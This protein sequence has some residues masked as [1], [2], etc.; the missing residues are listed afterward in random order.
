MHYVSNSKIKGRKSFVM[1]TLPRDIKTSRTPTLVHS[2]PVLS[3]L[4]KITERTET[5]AA[6]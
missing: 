1:S 5:D 4:S 2:N 6:T 3:R